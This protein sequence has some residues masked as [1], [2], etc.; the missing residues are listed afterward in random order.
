M[1]KLVLTYFDFDGGR[2]EPARLALT[3]GG[4][5]FEDRRIPGKEWPGLSRPDAVPL[6]AG[7]RGGR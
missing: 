5:A 2:G 7:A 3:I 6:H 4:I 1:P